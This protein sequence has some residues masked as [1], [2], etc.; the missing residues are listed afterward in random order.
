[1]FIYDNVL[2]SWEKKLQMYTHWEEEWENIFVHNILICEH[3]RVCMCALCTRGKTEKVLTRINN[4]RVTKFVVLRIFSCVQLDATFFVIVVFVAV[5]DFF[6]SIWFSLLSTYVCVCVYECRC[7]H[8]FNQRTQVILRS[9][10][11]YIWPPKSQV[12]LLA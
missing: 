8:H 5:V 12:T 4:R 10:R 9:S 6:F 3:A 1:M 7:K 2:T 11:G